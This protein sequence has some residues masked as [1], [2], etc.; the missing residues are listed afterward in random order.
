[1]DYR[2]KGNQEDWYEDSI[3]SDAQF[4]AQLQRQFDDEDLLTSQ[5]ASTFNFGQRPG[6]EYSR[7][8][9]SNNLKYSFIP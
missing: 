5:L 8:E 3:D 9:T 4:A 6:L 7:P 2:N 1:M